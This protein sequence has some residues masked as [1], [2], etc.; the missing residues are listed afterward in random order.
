MFISQSGYS[1]ALQ[2]AQQ[3]PGGIDYSAQPYSYDPRIVYPAVAVSM[4]NDHVEY[5]PTSDVYAQQPSHI[6][7]P[8][9]PK[10]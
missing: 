10:I 9:Y 2:Q 5:V 4:N 3:Q 7:G 8:F 6:E 1:P